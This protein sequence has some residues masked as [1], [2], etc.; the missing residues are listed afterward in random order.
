M[1]LPDYAQELNRSTM[2]PMGGTAYLSLENSEDPY[3]H[4]VKFSVMPPTKRLREKE[5]LFGGE[6]AA[7][8]QCVSP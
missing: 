5:Q 3:L 8:P 1:A 6:K 7:P 2:Q 4:G